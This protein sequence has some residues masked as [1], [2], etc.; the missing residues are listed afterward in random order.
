[1]IEIIEKLEKAGFRLSIFPQKQKD[2][3]FWVAG[4][5]IGEDNRAHWVDTN[6]N[7]PFACYSSYKEAF[8][9]TVNYCKNYGKKGRKKK[10]PSI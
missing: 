8:L 4:V 3:W 6:N 2:A 5:Y 9:N 1:M 7:L 10:S